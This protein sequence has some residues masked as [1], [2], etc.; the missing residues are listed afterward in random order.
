ME[1][2]DRR[3]G[4]RRVLAEEAP[5]KKLLLSLPGITKGLLQG[6]KFAEGEYSKERKQLRGIGDGIIRRRK[7]QAATK[8]ENQK[9]SPTERAL[10]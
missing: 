9:P 7:Q 2:Q 10:N 8:T 1:H 4:K 5:P 6:R 3:G